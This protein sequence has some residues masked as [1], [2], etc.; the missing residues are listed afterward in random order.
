MN[1]ENAFYD[2]VREIR[3]SRKGQGRSGGKKKSG[4]NIL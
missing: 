2:L 1:V 4:C 3:K